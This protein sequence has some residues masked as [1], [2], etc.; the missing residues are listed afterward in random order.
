MKLIA[1][2]AA[3]LLLVIAAC[4][5][6]DDDAPDPD[7]Q[8]LRDTMR[9]MVLQEEDVPDGMSV[10]GGEFSTNEQAA[11]GLGA[12]ATKEQLD[13]WGRVLGFSI[14]YQLTEPVD[15][16]VV[17]AIGSSV[18]VYG[19]EEGASESFSS[20][21]EQARSADWEAS[22]ADLTEFQQEE[23]MDALPADDQLW[24]RFTGFKE[25]AAGVNAMVAD[26]VMVFRIGD[27]WGFLNVI[28]TSQSGGTDREFN[29]ALVQDLA[30]QQIL[31]IEAGISTGNLDG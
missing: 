3:S 23:I 1:M 4:G 16:D 7:D 20:R 28:S 19:D 18:S 30:E 13:E 27:T 10:L 22:H 21:V 29:R 31:R 25:I 14:N 15:A 17:S 6:D 26:D 11:S 24:F 9:T 12:G 8:D 2:L 5:G